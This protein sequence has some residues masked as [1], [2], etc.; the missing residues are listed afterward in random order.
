MKGVKYKVK[1]KRRR[2]GKT[3]YA[4]RFK[5]LKSRTTRAVVRRTNK[6]FVVQFVDFDEKGD[7]VIISVH[8]N[9]LKKYSWDPKR[10]YPTAYLIGLYAGK[11]A[12]EKGIEKAIPDIKGRTTKGSNLFAVLKGIA[13]SIDIAY[14][15]DNIIEE[16]LNG[17]HINLAE[18]FEEVKKKI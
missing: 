14:P 18:K 10:N 8:S 13:E 11:L 17:S 1:F 7:K 4:R 2:Q 16:R 15:E 12:K 3:N 5:L 9:I 6:G